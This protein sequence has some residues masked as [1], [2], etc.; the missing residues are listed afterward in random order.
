MLFPMVELCS[1]ATPELK[2]LFAMVHRIK[3][4]PV[5]DIVDYFKNVHK[6]SGPIECTSMVTWIATNLGCP[7]MTNLAYIEGDVPIFGLDHFVQ[8]H[9]LCK[10]P[11]YSVSMLYGRKAIRLPNP[12]L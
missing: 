8:A 9:I 4:T 6:M 2:C 11:D 5:A 3:Y 12:A 10:E 7:K 1:V